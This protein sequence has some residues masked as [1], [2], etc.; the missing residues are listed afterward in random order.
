MSLITR[1]VL[2]LFGK[3]QVVVEELVSKLLVLAIMFVVVWILGFLGVGFLLWA[4][5]LFLATKFIAWQA[6]LITGVSAFVLIGL[7]A[8]ALSVIRGYVIRPKK[9]SGTEPAHHDMTEAVDLIRSHPLESGVLAMA[10]GFT[11][12]S[13]PEFKSVLSDIV[14]VL[15][16]ESVSK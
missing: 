6:A 14:W 8:I 15:K 2:S 5:Y 12:S 1:L 11:S 7:L 16:E 13:S 10:L 9:S 4:F 3:D